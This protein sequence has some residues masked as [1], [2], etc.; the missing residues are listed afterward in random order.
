MN[1]IQNLYETYDNC[2][3]EVG[4]YKSSGERPL[5]PICHITAEAQIEI[6]INETGGF[7][8]ANLISKDQATTIIPCTENSADRSGAKPESHPLCDKLQYISGDFRDYGGKVT[9]GFGKENDEPFNSYLQKLTDW[10]KSNYSHPKVESILYYV[11]KRSVI[12]DLVESEILFV[13]N[14]DKF[15]SKKDIDRNKESL[16]IFDLVTNQQDAFVR[17]GYLPQKLHQLVM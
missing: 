11:H 7:R 4:K 12:K 16:D 3:S 6:V 5:L 14:D 8:R 2:D 10:T 1:W 9:V 15:L 17:W 13:G